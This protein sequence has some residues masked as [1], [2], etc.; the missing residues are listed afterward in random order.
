MADTNIDI[1][2]RNEKKYIQQG[3]W[4]LTSNQSL[5]IIYNL[6]EV[7]NNFIKKLCCRSLSCNCTYDDEDK[8]RD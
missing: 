1:S 6:P 4:Q 5:A 3:T 2:V 7:L 8:Q